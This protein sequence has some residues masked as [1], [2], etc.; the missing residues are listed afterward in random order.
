MLSKENRVESGLGAR[1]S[2][3]EVRLK[4]EKFAGRRSIMLYICS[5]IGIK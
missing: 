2:R 1:L 4:V 3:H 5:G